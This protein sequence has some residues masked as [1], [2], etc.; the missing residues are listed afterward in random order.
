[1]QSSRVG[2]A[3]LQ[4]TGKGEDAEAKSNP[5]LQGSGVFQPI[6]DSLLPAGSTFVP[7][8]GFAPYPPMAAL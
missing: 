3:L 1:M 4:S 2:V 7:E 5:S 6:V 8:M